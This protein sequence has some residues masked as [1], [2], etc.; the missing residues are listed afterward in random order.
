MY[1][2]KEVKNMASLLWISCTMTILQ[3]KLLLLIYSSWYFLSFWCHMLWSYEEDADL[4]VW[5]SILIWA[6]STRFYFLFMAFLPPWPALHCVR[7]IDHASF[8]TD[9]DLHVS[10]RAHCAWCLMPP[11]FVF[12]DVKILWQKKSSCKCRC[13]QPSFKFSAGSNMEYASGLAWL[14]GQMLW[15]HWLMIR[16]AAWLQIAGLLLGG[17][18]YTQYCQSL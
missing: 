10:E 9:L 8:S 17:P 14:Y 5:L 6:C 13:L 3:F 2:F 18:G 1:T 4:T 11:Y 12:T 16:G 15:G 7:S